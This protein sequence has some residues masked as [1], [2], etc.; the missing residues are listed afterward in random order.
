MKKG[1]VNNNVGENI[2]VRGEHRIWTRESGLKTNR[3]KIFDNLNNFQRALKTIL[4]KTLIDKL[5]DSL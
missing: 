3:R 5:K 4:R 2:T 1:I